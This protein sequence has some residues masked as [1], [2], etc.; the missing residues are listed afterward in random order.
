M[1]NCLLGKMH[2]SAGEGGS[3]FVDLEFLTYSDAKARVCDVSATNI[4]KM[5]S[6]HWSG[7][8]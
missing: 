2:N 5:P 4:L 3:V 7:C 6:Q 1:Q 8:R